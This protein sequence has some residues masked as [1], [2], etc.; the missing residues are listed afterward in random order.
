MDGENGQ[1]IKMNKRIIT[2]VIVVAG[3]WGCRPESRDAA[4][5]EHLVAACKEAADAAR[6]PRRASRRRPGPRPPLSRAAQTDKLHLPAVLDRVP[7]EGHRQE[8]QRPVRGRH[9]APGHPDPRTAY[10]VHA[11]DRCARRKS[12]RWVSFSIDLI[13]RGRSSVAFGSC[14]V[15]RALVRYAA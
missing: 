7:A 5:W 9:A 1:E 14:C 8:N 15:C 4:S 3:I 6:P 10:G 2:I 13:R 12:R 11:F